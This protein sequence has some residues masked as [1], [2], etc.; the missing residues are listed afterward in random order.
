VIR[1]PLEAG[2]YLLKQY[3][4]K[5]RFALAS[6]GLTAH[7]IEQILDSM[8][9][10]SGIYLSLN[11][12]YE[13]SEEP[14]ANFARQH[15]LPEEV[16]A[17]FPKL[18]EKGLYI[19]QK[20]GVLS[21]LN[22]RHTIISTGTGS[23]KTETF[24]IPIIA[25]CLQ[26]TE[27]GVKAILIY[28]MNALAGDQIERIARYTQATNITF[29]LYTGATPENGLREPFER[30][31]ANQL[32]YRDEIRANPPDILITNYVMLDR[33]LT[34]EKDQPIFVE[35]RRTLRYLVL[36]E[37][38]TYTGSKGA[39]LKF[40]IARLNH[41]LINKP[42]YIGTSAT[43]ASDT[44]GRSRLNAFLQNLFDIAPDEYSLVEVVKNSADRLPLVQPAPV[45]TDEDL[46]ALAFP[47]RDESVAAASIAHLTGCEVSDDFFTQGRPFE[48]GSAYQALTNNHFVNIIREALEQGSQSFNDLVRHVS[49]GIP[50]EQFQA[51]T[52]ERLLSR[53]LEAIAYV[54]E[55]AGERGKPLLDYRLHIFVQNLTGTLRMCPSCHRY[56]SGDVAYCPHDGQTVFAVY[57]SDV[58]LCIGKFNGQS[59][60]SILEPESTDLENVH[61]VLIGRASESLNDDFELQGDLSIDG[62]FYGRSDGA[63]RL[64]HL[65]ARNLEQLEHHLIRIGDE[66]RDYLYLVHLVKTMLQ[67]YG[68]SLGFVDNRELASRYS[69]I[70]RDEFASEFLFEFLCLTY[71]RERDFGIDRLL[72]YLQKRAGELQGSELEQAIFKEL[73]IWFYR[74][75]AIPERL[76]GV[77]NLL[78]WRTGDFDRH[79]LSELQQ[80]LV[81]IFIRERAILTEFRDDTPESHYIRFQKYWATS[82]YG[83]YIE[84]TVSENADYRGISLNEHSQE[85]ADFV[86]DWSATA[87]KQ[88]VDELVAAEIMVR[89]TTPDGKAIYYLNRGYLC[90]DP[91]PSS[92]GEGE[93]G[94]ESLKKALLFTADVHSSDI[95]TD[96][97]ER[98]ETGFK[99]GDI[100]FVTATPTL[101]MGIDIGDLESVLMI[102]APPTPAN[103]AQRAGRAGRGKK[104]DAIIVTFCSADNTHD[105]YAFRNPQ[106]V[107]DGRVAPP[108]FNPTNAEILKK[109]INAFALRHH[110]KN[111]DLLQQFRFEVDRV[112]CDQISQMQALFGNWFDYAEYLN[113]FKQLLERIVRE[114]D[115]RRVA[116][117]C[118]R[119]GIFPD[120]G[121]R[122][123]QVIA[124]AVENRDQISAEQPFD[125]K[126]FAL[127]TR[128]TE[129]AFRFFVPD[130]VIYVAGEVYKTLNDGI[131][132]LLSDGA[133]QYSCFFAE[134]EVRF[135]QQ[136]KE[137]KH[138]DLRQHF[139]PTIPNLAELRGVL[140]IGYTEECILSFRN[141]GVRRPRQGSSASE[142]QTLIGYDLKR[143]AVVLRF[144]SFICNDMLRNSLT[145]VLA[146]EINRRYGLADGELRVMLEAKPPSE[147]DNSRWIYTLLYDNDGNNNLPLRNI[148]QEF[149]II[150]RS[151]Y[152]QLLSCN[153]KTD[154]CYRCIRSYSTQYFDATL[155]KDR[156]L[157]FTGY[158]SGE[159][160]FEPSVLPFVPT[161]PSID[162]VLTIRQQKNEIVVVSSAGEYY[163]QPV[164]DALNDTIFIT[165]TQAIYGE[166]QTG[167]KS[168]KIETWV[169]WLADSISNRRV[170]KGKEAFNR[171]QFALLKFDRVEAVS[172][173]MKKKVVL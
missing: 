18:A 90:I 75:I 172:D 131:Y 49:H 147:P 119:E 84:D 88:A 98:I 67:T 53:Y 60:S 15:H 136:R 48:L 111:G 62:Q 27:R 106:T 28:P 152:E 33:L 57:R 168:L 132:E 145:A 11:P 162:L 95:Q 7:T 72:A 32:I 21:I 6:N 36:D 123:D 85:Y 89:E 103:Y 116:N 86:E 113:E 141:H 46:E 38:H 59:L 135:A 99:K 146:R 157:M 23:G 114:T 31:F 58:R 138:L 112:Y 109:H 129:Q 12:L 156:A 101:E 154:G 63:F 80:A 96:E 50:T 133:R 94:Y 167:M 64:A 40:L 107:I 122:R 3:R 68:K 54:N 82:H 117:Y 127:T 108:A 125:W 77:A 16:V 150:V 41:Y 87:I 143:E 110:L 171:F 140:A 163:R 102:G 22:G 139:T 137:R 44:A 43:L 166:Y 134:K 121:F 128:D 55:K 34:R 71:P 52:P 24:L 159:R 61:Y 173:S 37:L 92:Y 2:Q 97:R 81:D 30:K 4:A 124:V 8:Q 115:G 45:L 73:P 69:T 26:S 42:T 93:D 160:R 47:L 10:D 149:N 170:N 169:N 39:H 17:S 9:I 142:T 105:T 83:I 79:D 35:A 56:F 161:H 165:L 158:L 13:P 100:H 70:I 29:G 19:H 126:D 5:L 1:N 104:R 51:I 74:M 164:Q 118:Y 148:F 14:F 65:D 91:Q 155:S 144:D 76:G 78:K 66:K 130:H 20:Q 120:Y 25:H 153:C 151:A